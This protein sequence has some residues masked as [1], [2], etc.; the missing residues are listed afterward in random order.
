MVSETNQQLIFFQF[1]L[2]TLHEH[3]YMYLY[4]E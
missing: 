1:V 4:T 3:T 2:A